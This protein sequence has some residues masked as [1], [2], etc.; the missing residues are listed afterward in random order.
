MIYV[1]IV[2]YLSIIGRRC[3]FMR[4]RFSLL[5]MA[6]MLIFSITVFAEV[7]PDDENFVFGRGWGN[8]NQPYGNGIRAAELDAYRKAA[9]QA[10]EIQ[11]DSDTTVENGLTTDT[12]RSKMNLLIKKA[13][14]LEEGKDANGYYAVVRV[15]IWGAQS[16]VASVVLPRNTTIESFPE[17]KFPQ[18]VSTVSGYTGLIVD[19]RG[20]GLTKAMSPVIKD[21]SNQPI[22]G[23][24][25][26]NYDDVVAQGMAS[27]TTS[28]TDG[29][30]RAGSN[31]LI[32]KAVKVEG[33]SSKCNPVVSAADASKILSANQTGHF[34]D[35]CAVVFV[36]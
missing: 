25:N 26:L 3:V 11:I 8:P 29:V 23:Y 33:Y 15:P 17:P 2:T 27:Y 21:D 9:E 5:T 19:C 16:S 12:M 22:Y 13:R 28:T 32:I 36:K 18:P 31:P 30:S 4:K 1:L 14:I 6:L 34:L 20:L 24:K 10:K 35:K 7:M